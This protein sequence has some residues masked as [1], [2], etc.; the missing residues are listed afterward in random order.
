MDHITHGMQQAACD[1]PWSQMEG[2]HTIRTCFECSHTVYK[3][4]GI[5]EQQLFE[6]I[7]SKHDEQHCAVKLYRRCDGTV[8][9]TSG[10]SVNLPPTRIA[11]QITAIALSVLFGLLAVTTIGALAWKLFQLLIM[12]ALSGH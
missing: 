8:T 1:H 3:V 4:D 5:G 12:L 11:G 2:S 6:L 10:R 7:S 9:T